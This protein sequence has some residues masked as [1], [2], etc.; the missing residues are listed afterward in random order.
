M[1]RKPTPAWT[2]TVEE[3][4]VAGRWH[5]DGQVL[6]VYAVGAVEARAEATRILHV[7]RA[8]APWKPWGRYSFVRTSAEPVEDARKY[9][10]K[11]RSSV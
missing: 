8:V 5:I 6:T 3:H 11:A 1:A 2:V 7:R 10:R 9:V 4:T